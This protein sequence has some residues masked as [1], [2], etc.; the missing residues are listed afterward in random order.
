MEHVYLVSE[1]DPYVYVPGTSEVLSACK[2]LKKA[3]D[4][5][6]GFADINRE[7]MESD[8]TDETI[9]CTWENHTTGLQYII[10]KVCVLT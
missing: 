4:F 3:F 6:V 7:E 1:Y 9:S 2:T 8:W 5:L 10:T